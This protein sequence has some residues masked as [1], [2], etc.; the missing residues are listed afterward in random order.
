[1]GEV[2]LSS[3]GFVR[4]AVML[5]EVAGQPV[6]FPL[7]GAFV[8]VRGTLRQD[9]PPDDGFGAPLQ[10][11]VV[12]VELTDRDRAVAQRGGEV[13]GVAG[14]FLLGQL[15]PQP[16]RLSSRAARSAASRS[17]SARTA[18]LTVSPTHTPTV[19]I[20]PTTTGQVGV[21]VTLFVSRPTTTPITTAGTPSHNRTAQGLR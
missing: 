3:P 12:T 21:V 14:G 5:G 7:V 11:L 18:C 9:P 8:L 1:M 10:L 2:V 19:A 15:P 16:Q 20:S 4:L 6:L 17:F 13:G